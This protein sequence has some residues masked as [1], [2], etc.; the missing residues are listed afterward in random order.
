MKKPCQLLLHSY[1]V[2][3]TFLRALPFFFFFCCYWA[4]PPALWRTYGIF[5]KSGKKP[6]VIGDWW[7]RRGAARLPGRR[8]IRYRSRGVHV[9]RETRDWFGLKTDSNDSYQ[10]K[11]FAASRLNG[12]TTRFRK[13]V[14]IYIIIGTDVYYDGEVHTGEG[15]RWNLSKCIIFYRVLKFRN[16]LIKK[17]AINKDQEPPLKNRDGG[18]GRLLVHVSN[19]LRSFRFRD[20]VFDTVVALENEHFF[21]S[22]LRQNTEGAVWKL[23][24]FRQRARK[25]NNRRRVSC[26]R[27]REREQLTYPWNRLSGNNARAAGGKRRPLSKPSLM[28]SIKKRTHN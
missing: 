16:Y 15:G 4:T 1:R 25:T 5:K 13:A 21:R 6:A 7:G 18:D 10:I 23:R 28:I 14:T 9:D 27:T 8:R 12:K 2:P 11:Q 22:R 17:N 3:G 20:P 24:D 19:H 26:F